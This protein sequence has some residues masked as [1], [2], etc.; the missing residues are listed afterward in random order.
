MTGHRLPLIVNGVVQTPPLGD[1]GTLVLRRL[2]CPVS[3]DRENLSLNLLSSSN[4]SLFVTGTPVISAIGNKEGVPKLGG[5]Q[6]TRRF[7]DIRGGTGL[8]MM[9]PAYSVVGS[10]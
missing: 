3:A 1:V 7:A 4:D 2:W 9:K 6:S 5:K 8:K 10:F